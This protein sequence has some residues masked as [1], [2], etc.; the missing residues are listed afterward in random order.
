MS[1]I[2]QITPFMHV[3]D[4]ENAVRFFVEVL[5]FT[6]YIEGP[7]Y[8][9]VQREAAGMRIL[10][11]STSPGEI[12][13]AG[14]CAFRYYID[15]K[16]VDAI[17]AEIKPKVEA[18]PGSRLHGPVN[19]PYGQREVMVLA[20]D[21]DLVVF[22]QEIVGARESDAAATLEPRTDAVD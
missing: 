5:G 20:P 22:G 18:W 13:G 17:Y 21:G 1:N 9:Y 7:S 12:P 8:A 15:V 3:A 10:R 2:L 16:D 19:Q 6:A 11:A 14:T 4:V